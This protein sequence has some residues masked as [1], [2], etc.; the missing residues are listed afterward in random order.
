MKRVVLSGAVVLSVACSP[1]TLEDLREPAVA[2]VITEGGAFCQRVYAVDA[3]GAV[4][5]ESGCETSSSGLT[6]AERRVSAAEASEIEAAFD[7]VLAIPEDPD[8]AVPSPSGRRY[9]FVRTGGAPE[10]WPE[11]RQCEP[12]VPTAAL[13]LADRLEALAAPGS[14]GDAG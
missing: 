12:G 1:Q 11:T 7:A 14:T 13:D 6:Q 5:R 10:E 8:C 2:V 4:F 3:D 9:R